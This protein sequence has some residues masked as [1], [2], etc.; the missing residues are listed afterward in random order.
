MIRDEDKSCVWLRFG[1]PKPASDFKGA[2]AGIG[3]V[4]KLCSNVLL[5][6]VILV[7]FCFGTRG[8]AVASGPP[9]YMD[10][11]RD[12][13]ASIYQVLVGE[14]SELSSRFRLG[15]SVVL[16]LCGFLPKARPYDDAGKLSRP[17]LEVER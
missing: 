11:T 14:F 10:P 2:A 5:L 17:F 9:Q 6:D 7:R 3:T 4:I 15:K 16:H 13:Q 8:R 1:S 12:T